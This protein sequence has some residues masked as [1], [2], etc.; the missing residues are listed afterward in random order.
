MIAAVPL[1]PD[2]V[3]VFDNL[4]L[5]R[6][7]LEAAL[8]RQEIRKLEA[9]F[10]QEKE[11]SRDL[12]IKL[13]DAQAEQGRVKDLERDVHNLGKEVEQ[14]KKAK[15]GTKVKLQAAESR[16]EKLSQQIVD[17]RNAHQSELAEAIKAG[18]NEYIAQKRREVAQR[19]GGAGDV[20]PRS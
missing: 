15:G 9:A 4:A 7:R 18:V 19:K 2:I 14:W 5:N 3:S 8:L 16:S 13:A 17:E 20:P 10:Q 11:R 12:E 1:Y 6:S